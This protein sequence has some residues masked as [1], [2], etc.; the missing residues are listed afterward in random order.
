M[1]LSPKYNVI[2]II[3]DALRAKNLSSYGYPLPTSINID[4]LVK[5]G[6]KFENAYAC[7]NATDPSFTTIFT[8]RFPL[9]HGILH[10]GPY[11]TREEMM[12][13]RTII[14]LPEILR[15][16]GYL[17]LAVDWL[18][19]WHKRGYDFYS[20]SSALDQRE[21][22]FKR[23]PFNFIRRFSGR[24]E[25]QYIVYVLLK[26]ALRNKFNI[27]EVTY[28]NARKV[29]DLA[30]ELIKKYCKRKFF[31]ALHYEDNHLPYSPPISYVNRFYHLYGMKYPKIKLDDIL[32]K[33]GNPKFRLAMRN[34]TI[35]AESTDELLARYDG[36][37]SFVDHEIGRLLEILDNYGLSD[38]TI[39]VLTSDHGESLLEHEIF[40]DHHGLYE[41]VIHVPLIIKGPGL[42]KSKRIKNLVQH[43][44]ILPTLLDLL[45][46]RKPLFL[47]GKS[48][49]SLIYSSKEEKEAHPTAYFEEY[50]Y[51]QKR[52]IR[53]GQYKYIR[54]LSYK[55]AICKV[56]VKVHGGIEELYDLSRDP[57]EV[58]NIINDEPELAREFKGLLDEWIR[59]LRRKSEKEKIR[60]K[61]KEIRDII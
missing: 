35:D 11:V 55:G 18:G 20:G 8:G 31:L 1:N 43:T 12:R 7:T 13:V 44:D 5:E 47:D 14:S 2:L 39:I 38:E 26:A 34:L 40:F 29:T 22:L 15:S 59:S 9:C 54:A 10:H 3:I 33:I 60:S 32:R 56:C 37:I 46:I 4:R 17:T 21:P 50:N 23:I 58:R 51:E 16:N 24:P 52:S 49:V 30:I 45:D 28:F 57:K 53:V 48:L 41:E 25:I 19:R 61:L 42:P 6:V 27:G 36:E